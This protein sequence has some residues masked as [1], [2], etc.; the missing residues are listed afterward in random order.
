[1]S[2]L[3]LTCANNVQDLMHLLAK[4]VVN[5]PV[6]GVSYLRVNATYH[7][8][9][10]VDPAISCDNAGLNPEYLLKKLFYVDCDGKLTINIS[11]PNP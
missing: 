5:D 2:A 10:E 3:G 6:T 8:C 4:A 7:D 1:M 9:E 11:M